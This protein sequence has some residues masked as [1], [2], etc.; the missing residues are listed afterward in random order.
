MLKA[1][2]WFWVSGRH[3]EVWS[4]LL[5]FLL[6]IWRGKSLEFF[7]I[8]NQD[9]WCIPIDIHQK[10]ARQCIC[11]A[12][13]T[14]VILDRHQNW[15][16]TRINKK[17]NFYNQIMCVI[18]KCWNL[19][20]G[21]TRHKLVSE[22]I[23][24]SWVWKHRDLSRQRFLVVVQLQNGGQAPERLQGELFPSCHAKTSFLHKLKSK[25]RQKKLD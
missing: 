24:C 15:N 23:H 8:L 4:E 17:N 11:F 7:W 13:Y 6:L 5:L 9:W 19:Q 1:F 10:G 20:V 21:H 25:G 2:Y 3:A 22:Y 14:V 16:P 18:I 12:D